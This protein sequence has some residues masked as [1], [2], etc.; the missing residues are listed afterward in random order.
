MS[1]TGWLLL[2][3][4]L[5]FVTSSLALVAS[6]GVFLLTRANDRAKDRELAAYQAKATVEINQARNDAAQATAHSKDLDLRIEETK[7]TNIGLQRALE[8]ERQKRLAFEG[9]FAWRQIPDFAM[10][11]IVYGLKTEQPGKINILHLMN[12]PESLY[13]AIMIERIFSAAGWT[14]NAAAMSFPGTLIGGITTPNDDD[15]TRKI[16]ALFKAN[17]VMIGIQ[18]TPQSTLSF[19]SAD[20]SFPITI[21]VGSHLPL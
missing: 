6:I 9:K 5:F 13:L 21:L 17:G 1:L 15:T 20:P 8:D 2:S 3:N 11:N 12:D 16:I 18:A 10:N 7:I 14:V 4:S 19:G